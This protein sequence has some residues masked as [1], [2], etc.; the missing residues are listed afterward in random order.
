[1]LAVPH[2]P[3]VVEMREVEDFLLH[4]RQ[5]AGVL[6]QVSVDGSAATFATTDDEEFRKRPETSGKAPVGLDQA[7]ERHL[8]ETGKPRV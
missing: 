2:L 4:G 7:L 1:M 3:F 5:H 8:Q 6:D